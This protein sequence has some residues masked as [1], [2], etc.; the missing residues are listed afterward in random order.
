[1]AVQ[2][3]KLLPTIMRNTRWGELVEVVQ[4][5]DTQLRTDVIQPIY[6]QF[7]ITNSTSEELIR[8]GKMLGF[9]ILSFN[10]TYT[11]TLDYLRK[12]VSTIVPRIKH[13]NA[14]KSYQYTSY[15]FGLYNE[16]YPMMYNGAGDFIGRLSTLFDPASQ[17]KYAV[18]I[19]DQE[20]DN[21]YYDQVIPNWTLDSDLFSLDNGLILD[22]SITIYGDPKQTGLE[23]SFTDSNDTLETDADISTVN[24][25]PTGAIITQLTR[26][27]LYCYNHKYLENSSEWLSL[28]SLKALQNDINQIHKATEVIYYE[29]WL[30]LETNSVSGVTSNQVYYNYDFSIS[31]V[32]NSV[33]TGANLQNASYIQFGTGN[34][35][36]SI[37][38]IPYNISGVQSISYCIPS[39]VILGVSYCNLP[40]GVGGWSLYDNATSSHLDFDFVI[41]E[42]NKFTQ[43]TELAV[44]NSTSGCVYYASF[45]KVQWSPYMNNNIRIE[46]NLV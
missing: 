27:I 6:N 26:N 25:I 17:I 35:F 7:T 38:G 22:Y 20:G 9:N 30:Q 33:L 45:P 21:V 11:S 40:S 12:E 29:P 23:E 10:D 31:G 32:I 14:K 5:V 19:T 18:I 28:Y 16:L 46:I 42:H 15:V 43:F 3:K 36:E 24:N 13:K 41:S 37:S 2:F 39:G 44:L 8:L 1:M 4:N 34:Y